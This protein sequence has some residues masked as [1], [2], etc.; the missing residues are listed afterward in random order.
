MNS[1]KE[2]RGK[3]FYK[4]VFYCCYKYF[5]TLLLQ[6]KTSFARVRNDYSERFLE[7]PVTVSVSKSTELGRSS[8]AGKVNTAGHVSTQNGRGNTMLEGAPH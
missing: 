3:N 5:V 8:F 2:H 6:L 4:L 1:L 7:R